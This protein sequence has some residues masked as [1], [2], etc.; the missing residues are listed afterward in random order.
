MLIQKTMINFKQNL[1]EKPK[2]FKTSKELYDW[3]K[4]TDPIFFDANYNYDSITV[5][6]GAEYARKRIAKK[7]SNHKME[8]EQISG[9]LKSKV[10][11]VL[12]NL[13]EFK[14]T[15]LFLKNKEYEA[16]YAEGLNQYMGKRMGAGLYSVNNPANPSENAVVKNVKKNNYLRLIIKNLKDKP[17]RSYIIFD[18]Y[19]V[20]DYVLGKHIDFC[21]CRFL[22]AEEIKKISKKFHTDLDW[23]LNSL[24]NATDFIKNSKQFKQIILK[25]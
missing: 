12:R 9:D 18:N 7:I 21:Q 8:A 3:M 1:S 4:K 6:S 24:K 5:R 22:N 14:E 2:I 19:I 10:E 16:C 15:S 23:I 17:L 13:D 25:K 11:N 20:K